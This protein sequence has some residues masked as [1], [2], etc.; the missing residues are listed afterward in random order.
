MDILLRLSSI[1]QAMVTPRMG[2]GV[3]G[4]EGV[5]PKGETEVTMPE[6]MK[7]ASDSCGSPKQCCGAFDEDGDDNVTLG[8]FTAGSANLRPPVPPGQVATLFEKVDGDGSDGIAPSE[9]YAEMCGEEAFEPAGLIVPEFKRHAQDT[10]GSSKAANAAL[11]A[12]GD[13]NVTSEEFVEE[14]K[15]LR[16]PV[17]TC[18]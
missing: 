13:R 7:R 5:L 4:G 11:D 10:L 9:L 3:T 15:K 17:T 1:F 14:C 12:N 6:F 18:G 8:E 16:P 2:L